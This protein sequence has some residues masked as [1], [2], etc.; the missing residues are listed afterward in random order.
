MANQKKPTGS[1]IPKGRQPATQPGRSKKPGAGFHPGLSGASGIGSNVP[2]TRNKLGGRV[3]MPRQGLHAV[4]SDRRRATASTNMAPAY[5][6]TSPRFGN[7][8]STR[9]G[10]S[11]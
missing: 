8:N 4:N 2:V 3:K 6:Y 9:R 7:S 1:N 11:K 5:N 10:K